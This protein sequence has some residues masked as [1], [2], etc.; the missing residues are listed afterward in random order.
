MTW[1]RKRSSDD[2]YVSA[3]MMEGDNNVEN[4]AGAYFSGTVRPGPDSAVTNFRARSARVGTQ[5][6]R[7]DTHTSENGGSSQRETAE[8]GE[9]CQRGD[10]APSAMGRL[11][12][13]PAARLR[14]RRRGRKW[15]VPTGRIATGS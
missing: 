2:R 6:D 15:P 14:I 3:T 8:L 9:F 4:G 5:G 1:T 11:R 13:G 10:W 12:C 7:V